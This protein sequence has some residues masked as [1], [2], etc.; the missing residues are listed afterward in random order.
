MNSDELAAAI[1]HLKPNAEYAFEGADYSTIRWDFIE[2]N[3]PTVAELEAANEEL[4]KIAAQKEAETAAK[5]AA[6]EAK[7]A[8][9]GLDADD[10][11]TLGLA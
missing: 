5:R 1:N 7:L 6:V 4:K 11:K 3:A 8:A 10:L 2:G 9:L